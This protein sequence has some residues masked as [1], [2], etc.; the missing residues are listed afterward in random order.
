[1]TT[2]SSSSYLSNDAAA[3]KGIYVIVPAYNEAGSVGRVVE[4]LL[5]VYPN[6]L[7]VDDGSTDHTAAV[8]R[9]A[10]AR[11]L[12]H[13]VNR[14][15]GAAIQTGIEFALQCGA[16]HL[17]TFDADG[18]HDV[19]DIG[20][21]LEPIYRGQCDVA[22]G[23]RFLGEAVDL[24]GSRRLLLQLGVIFTRLTSG[25]NLTDTHNGLRA[26]NRRAAEKIHITLDGMAHA[27]ELIDQIVRNAL[28]YREVPVT[29]RY[30]D[31]SRAKGQSS[32]GAIKIALH[33]L[34]GRV[35]R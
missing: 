25:A 26:M 33:Y 31:Y 3:R 23:S 6:V 17:V 13:A 10:R 1:M 18:Q 2:A 8:A 28:T 9:G 27:S 7:V 20:R 15:Q 14:G 4:S 24:P 19:A 16:T 32:R 21:L 29:I 30:T 22:L 34:I 11:V 5:E 35:L 12:R